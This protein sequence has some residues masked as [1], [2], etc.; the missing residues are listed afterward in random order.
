MPHIIHA[1]NVIGQWEVPT[2]GTLRN[3]PIYKIPPEALY[4][5]LNVLIRAGMLRSRPGLTRLAP[6]L[7]TGRPTGMFSSIILAT[8]A[9]QADMVP[10]DTFQSTGSVPSALLMVGTTTK[11]YGFYAGV[12][13]DLT[14]ASGDLTALDPQLSRFTGM[15]LGTPQVLYVLHTNGVDAAR[16]WDATSATFSAVLGSPPLFIDWTNISEH[17]IGLVSTYDIRWGNTQLINTWPA[18]NIR[19]LS[20]TP[21]PTRAI[22]ALGP[23]AGMVYKSG[24]IWAVVVTGAAA[25][26]AYFR[27]EHRGMYDGPASAAAL[28]VCERDSSH[29]YMTD[30]GRIGYYNGSRHMWVGDGVWQLVKDDIDVDNANRIFGAYDPEFH[31]AVF[32]YPRTGDAGECK[33]WAIVQLPNPMEGYNDFISFHGR[34]L[35]AMSAGGSLKFATFKAVFAR[36]D[37]NQRRVYTWEGP[38]DDGS[39]ITGHWQT[40]L[41]ATPGVE[42][43]TLEA[44]ET[45]A[46]RGAGYGNL[47]SRVVSSYILGTEGGTQAPIKTI[48]LTNTTEVLGAHKGADVKGRF[49]GLRFEFVTPITLRWLGA[50]LSALLRKG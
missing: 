5:S 12:L 24:S 40:G 26:S 50:R 15:A 17:I 2:A 44:Y 3:M 34:S 45:F 38:D 21:D 39:A 4:S 28:V 22:A 9:F 8:S 47:D 42:F 33:G 25:E 6:T 14:G 35:L 43:F 18:A 27:F 49:F 10:A 13:N 32:C 20:D 30:R 41:V 37:A 36:S 48:D 31:I 46:L 1:T 16:Q 29:M 7:M 23:T 11:L 19:V